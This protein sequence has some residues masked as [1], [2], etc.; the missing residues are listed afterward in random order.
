MSEEPFNPLDRL[1]LTGPDGPLSVN[2]LEV[3]SYDDW[4]SGQPSQ[5]PIQAHLGYG[6][7]LREEYI[8]N[9]SYNEDVEVSIQSELGEALAAK[10]LLTN[11]NSDAVVSQIDAYNEPTLDQQVRDM[12]AHTSLEQDEWHNGNAYLERNEGVKTPEEIERLTENALAS[13]NATRNDVLQ[14]KLDAGEISFGRFT[15]AQGNSFIKAGDSAMDLPLHEALRRSKAAGGGVSLSDAIGIEQ[16]GLLKVADGM[17]IPRYKMIQLGEI[18]SLVR[19]EIANDDNLSIQLEAIGKRMAERDYSSFDHFEEGFRKSVGSTVRT[20]FEPIIGTLG[21]SMPSGVARE[22][23]ID[24][25]MLDDIDST[26]M[27]VAKKFNKNPEDVRLAIQ[28]VAIQNAPLKVFKDKDKLALNIRDDGYGLPFVPVAVKLDDDLF[29]KSLAARTDLTAAT[30][31]AIIAERD[32]F[33]T[34]HFSNISNILANS[35]LSKKWLDHLNAGRAAKVSDKEILFSFTSNEDNKPYLDLPIFG[36]LYLKG[37]DITRP[38]STAFSTVFALSGADWAKKHLANVA[39]DQNNRREIAELFGGKLGIAQDL[40]TLIPEVTV[41]IGATALLTRFGGKG[42]ATKAAAVKAPLY[43]SM[44]KKGV[45]KALTTNAFRRGVGETTEELAEKLASQKLIRSAT[46]KT[47]LEALEAYNKV[48]LKNLT[49]GAIGITAA[50]RSSGATYGSVYNSMLK[51]GASEEEAHDRALGTGMVAGAVTG[52]VTGGFSYFGRGGMEDALLSGMSY[53]NMKT[54]TERIVQKAPYAKLDG[55]SDA[56]FQQAIK[57]STKAVLKGNFFGKSFVKAGAEEFAEESIDEFINTFVT[58]AGLEQDTPFFDHLKH[59]LYAGTLGGILGAGAPAVNAAA[60]R[61]RPDLVGDLIQDATLEQN[62][63]NDITN[64]LRE[65]NSSVTADVVRDILTRDLTPDAVRTPS[66]EDIDAQELA[67]Q[68]DSEEVKQQAQFLLEIMRSTPE[69]Q[70]QEEVDAVRKQRRSRKYR[71][72]YAHSSFGDQMAYREDLAQPVIINEKGEVSD[73][74]GVGLTLRT[75]EGIDEFDYLEMG[76]AVE[77]LPRLEKLIRANPDILAMPDSEWAT[78]DPDSGVRDF[79]DLDLTKDLLSSLTETEYVQLGRLRDRNKV[80]YAGGDTVYETMPAEAVQQAI[81]KSKNVENKKPTSQIESDEFFTA[82]H[83]WEIVNEESG[84]QEVY[85]RGQYLTKKEA[86]KAAGFKMELG[87]D[88]SV[89]EFQAK[90]KVKRVDD[91]GNET[92]VDHPLL[93]KKTR[94]EGKEKPRTPKTVTKYELVREGAVETEEVVENIPA[95]TFKKGNKVKFVF[96]LGDTEFEEGVVDKDYDGDGTVDVADLDGNVFGLDPEQIIT[97]KKQATKTKEKKSADKVIGT[98]DTEAQAQAAAKKAEGKTFVRKVTKSDNETVSVGDT[99]SQATDEG[100]DPVIDKVHEELLDQIQQKNKR[101]KVRDKDGTPRFTKDEA[102]KKFAELLEKEESKKQKKELTAQEKFEAILNKINKEENNGSLSPDAAEIAKGKVLGKR[103]RE[104]TRKNKIEEAKKM[105]ADA[106]SSGKPAYIYDSSTKSLREAKINEKTGKVTFSKKSRPVF[107]EN[108]AGEKVFITSSRVSGKTVFHKVGEQPADPAGAGVVFRT[109]ENFVKFLEAGLDVTDPVKNVN[110][111]GN[112]KAS[113]LEALNRIVENGLPIIG[114]MSAD[115]GRTF[116]VDTTRRNKRPFYNKMR[117]LVAERI[118]NLFP[119]IN[120]RRPVNGKAIYAK[121]A[122]TAYSPW[123]FIK[124]PAG[125]KLAAKKVRTTSLR[126]TNIGGVFRAIAEAVPILELDKNNK[127]KA[128]KPVAFVDENDEGVFDNDPIS[129]KVLLEEGYSVYFPDD[130]VGRLNPAFR[131]AKI[132]TRQKLVD[133]RGVGYTGDIS[134]VKQRKAVVGDI[135]VEGF[136]KKVKFASKFLRR[137]TAQDVEIDDPNKRGAKTTLRQMLMDLHDTINNAFKAETYDPKDVQVTSIE[138]TFKFRADELKELDASLDRA[139]KRLAT[140]TPEEQE[141]AARQIETVKARRDRFYENL[142]VDVLAEAKKIA[143]PEI[144]NRIATYENL[145]FEQ[146]AIQERLGL[147]AGEKEVAGNQTQID[148]NYRIIEQAVFKKEAIARS[149]GLGVTQDPFV[150]QNKL[151]SYLKPKRK[152][153][154]LTKGNFELAARQ[155]QVEYAQEILFYQLKLQL[156]DPKISDVEENGAIVIKEEQIEKAINIFLKN[157]NPTAGA[158]PKAKKGSD[159]RGLKYDAKGRVTKA[160]KIEFAYYIL[161]SQIDT[162]VEKVEKGDNYQKVFKRY[163]EDR[164]LLR[165]GVSERDRMPSFADVGQKITD[166][167]LKQQRLRGSAEKES[168]F[169]SERA[170]TP[171]EVDALNLEMDHFVEMRM[172]V[173][174]IDALLEGV[175]M[176]VVDIINQDPAL[177]QQL[178]ALLKEGPFALST[179]DFYLRLNVEEKWSELVAFSR[180]GNMEGNSA[181][182][183]FL[184]NIRKLNSPA[185]VKLH[186]ALRL[187]NIGNLEF[188]NKN[189]FI[190]EEQFRAFD[191]EQILKDEIAALEGEEIDGVVRSRDELLRFADEILDAKKYVRWLTDEVRAIETQKGRV[192]DDFK[193]R[194]KASSLHKIIKAYSSHKSFYSGSAVENAIDRA[195]AIDRNRKVAILLGL[196]EGRNDTERILNA[197]KKI[198]VDDSLSESQQNA[199]RILLMKPTYVEFILDQGGGSYAGR[200]RIKD[201]GRIEVVLDIA[202]YNGR[203]LVD[204]LLHE[205]FHAS[206]LDSF[207]IDINSTSKPQ[208]DARFAISQKIREVRDKVGSNV[209]TELTDGLKNIQEFVSNMMTNTK[210]QSYFRGQVGTPEFKKVVQNLFKVLDPQRSNLSKKFKDA[211]YDVVDLQGY[212]ESTPITLSGLRQEAVNA[213][214]AD[215][216]ESD[217]FNASFNAVTGKEGDIDTDTASPLE[218]EDIAVR[219]AEL[220]QLAGIKIPSEINVA[221]STLTGGRVANFDPA[222]NTITFDANNAAIGTLNRGMD[223]LRA[224]QMVSKILRHELAHKSAKSALTP[225]MIQ[226]VIDG[227]SLQDF[228][229]DIDNYYG[230]GTPEAEAALARLNDPSKAAREKEVLVQERLADHVERAIGGFSSQQYEAFLMSNP[231]LLEVVSFYFKSFINKFIRALGGGVGQLTADER[232]AV[233]RMLV[234]L[235]GIELGYRAPSP[236]FNPD[237]T[238]QESLNRFLVVATGVDAPEFIEDQGATNLLPQVGADSQIDQPRATASTM[239]TPRELDGVDQEYINLLATANV[240]PANLQKAQDLFETQ[241]ARITLD[242]FQQLAHSVFVKQLGDGSILKGQNEFNKKKD[243][244]AKLDPTLEV[245]D[246]ETGETRTIP[247]EKY[248]ELKE[249]FEQKEQLAQKMFDSWKVAAKIDQPVATRDRSTEPLPLS[250]RFNFDLNTSEGSPPIPDTDAL[251]KMLGKDLGLKS[252]DPSL[253]DDGRL[254]SSFRAKSRSAKD[255]E[256]DAF[257]FNYTELFDQFNLP[258]LEVGDVEVYGKG[259]INKIKKFVNTHSIGLLQPEVHHWLKHRQGM[260]KGLSQELMLIR[261]KLKSL[262]DKVYPDGVPVDENGV[263]LV[264]KASGSTE[265]VFISDEARKRIDDQYEADMVAAWT[266]SHQA[267]LDGTEPATKIKADFDAAL[268]A[269]KANQELET[270]IEL[271]RRR[272]QLKAERNEAIQRIAQD[273]KEL[274]NAIEKLG[275]FRN[276]MSEKLQEIHKE[277][278]KYDLKIDQNNDIYLTRAYRMFLDVGYA[279]AVRNSPEY[280]KERDAAIAYFEGVHLEIEKKIM[281]QNNPQMTPTE[282]ESAIRD[283]MQRRQIGKRALEAFISTYDR[284]SNVNY[285]GAEEQIKALVDNLKAKKNIPKE[286]RDIL[287]ELKDTNLPDNLLRTI[288]VVGNMAANQSFLN[289][290]AKAG[291]KTE[292]NPDG[293]LFTEEQIA[294]V[295]NPSDYAKLVEGSEFNSDFSPLA[296]LYAKVNTANA[297]RETFKRHG[298]IVANPSEQLFENGF[299]YFRWL[300]GLSMG[301]KTMGSIPFY[302]RNAIGNVLFFGPMQVGYINIF[303]VKSVG[304]LVNAGLHKDFAV[305]FLK[306]SKRNFLGDKAKLDEYIAKLR[307]LRLVGDE[308]HTNTFKQLMTGER[309]IDSTLEDFESIIQGK[310]GDLSLEGKVSKAIGATSRA[311]SRRGKIVGTD[312]APRMAAAMDSFYKMSMFEF[313]LKHLKA[314]QEHDRKMNPDSTLAKQSDDQLQKDAAQKVLRTMQSYSQAPP[315]ARAASRSVAGALYAPFIRF[316]ADVIRVMVNTPKIAL[317]EI[318][319]GNPILKKRGVQRFSGFVQTA[320]LASLG[321]PLLLRAI[322]GISDDEDE[323]LKAAG[324]A[325]ARYNNPL[326]YKDDNGK[327]QMLNF[328]YTNPFSPVTDSIAATA[329]AVFNPDATPESAATT[330]FNSFLVKNFLSDQIFAGAAAEA[331]SGEDMQTGERVFIDGIDK[332][333]DKHIKQLAHIGKEAFA[334]RTLQNVVKAIRNSDG[335]FTEYHDSPMG[336]VLNE[337]NPIRAAFRPI[338]VNPSDKFRSFLFK[339]EQRRK[340]I[341]EKFRPLYKDDPLSPEDI[342]GIYDEV[343]KDMESLN[344][345]VMNKFQAFEKIGIPKGKLYAMARGS[346][347]GPKLGKRRSQ[348]LLL[349]YMERPVLEANKV[350]I[351]LSESPEMQERVRVFAEAVKRYPRFSKVQ[352]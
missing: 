47:A 188:G 302:Y 160:S 6:D 177:E 34:N 147:A 35:D 294:G 185:A 111:A 152:Q 42:V 181:P 136:R 159:Y 211:F 48:N 250:E 19:S 217:A 295:D 316:Q 50:N 240:S 241:A 242:S 69:D 257:D 282:V 226:R 157:V 323:A 58:D 310:E 94:G 117:Q 347:G 238:P 108:I 102:A 267:S 33:A 228:K 98:F 93:V 124:T 255:S 64:R 245:K 172:G 263:S 23:A 97:G 4:S 7:Y 244:F 115:S 175:Q 251:L 254:Y 76:I 66:Q 65:S 209:T 110:W 123:E 352:D 41:D 189:P 12:V 148:A 331:I 296:G 169:N 77:D 218:L 311:V 57:D 70:I 78:Y 139:N 264:Q 280:K 339:T 82:Y 179:T 107:V 164:I 345:E 346:G 199:A 219:A 131:F 127:P 85:S 213:A 252:Q 195:V 90:S 20:I 150:A 184:Q 22:K 235:R 121:T 329:G 81:I 114:A 178:D 3:T 27:R 225:E 28:E 222:T 227:S 203:G 230:K 1:N 284:G 321:L 88:P 190:L 327:L 266:E 53:R 303:N 297:F 291:L 205:Y 135:N 320:G 285:F 308:S 158:N 313:E 229:N 30:K 301:L 214:V 29:E 206:L 56:V 202:G 37:S 63:I 344:K 105:V 45:L 336:L 348:L 83:L 39:E 277:S 319:S 52:L 134:S 84:Q 163:F 333:F 43:A 87:G 192:I 171:D 116:G 198:A 212:E 279:D 207:S 276:K 154:P 306:E 330:L 40:A 132:G 232:I 208:R 262:T 46:S 13:V 272:D 324:P 298:T 151:Q 145:L 274:S 99:V 318:N 249:F 221:F 256:F 326:Y 170:T 31:K 182:I 350:R 231:S 60:R 79:R 176:D 224:A 271:G 9:K 287:G 340:Q 343:Y 194:A 62:L 328:T 325:W 260:T 307:V 270:Q 137:G 126:P 215:I 96:I 21:G 71:S 309:D 59:S 2:K 200:T 26:V 315:I 223:S 86:E 234:E 246:E 149:E 261:S 75:A 173:G 275:E 113:E 193:A 104:L 322:F 119:V 300:T 80:F 140:G 216:E 299:K 167:I 338:P 146:R 243:E 54:V 106:I 10:G 92:I 55:V 236:V 8:K 165:D 247:N 341:R 120:V 265:G 138:E 273:S 304:D 109:K 187:F 259:F 67:Q 180:Q 11:E 15:D 201:D 143:D 239:A 210:F 155:L 314:A 166:R 73:L 258:V 305:N 144:E 122:L 38:F 289:A 16:V 335:D 61:L 112:V 332:G 283:D 25:A 281:M 278:G 268:E 17:N 191:S 349:G 103:L 269:A 18:E 288:M 156:A 317:E 183:A 351:M 196:K 130:F 286:L 337:V 72:A 129:M 153:L 118:Y 168:P 36:D 32:F 100:G 128:H 174:E 44:T 51:S 142:R 292:D 233:N 162:R 204:V 24:Q 161:N 342:F 95:T 101:I 89:E 334:P 74:A 49:V 248:Q 91:D 253:D 186:R 14:A 290:V 197:L 237:A 293:W 220:K 141:E 125:Q 5:D 133:I 312:L 68:D